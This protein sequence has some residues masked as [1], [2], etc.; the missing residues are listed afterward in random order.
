MQSDL[1][2]DWGAYASRVLVLVPSPT[3]PLNFILLFCFRLGKL[4]TCRTTNRRAVRQKR[5]L[6]L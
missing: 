2:T 6:L 4:A 1:C 3:R 5:I